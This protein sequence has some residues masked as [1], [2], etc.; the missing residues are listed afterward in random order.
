MNLFQNASGIFV[1]I[2]LEFEKKNLWFTGTNTHEG[3]RGLNV[4]FS[5][6]GGAK[7]IGITLEAL[8]FDIRDMSEEDRVFH[9]LK[10]LD[11]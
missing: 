7:K 8:M 5:G 6:I 3:K 4:P 10:G 9:F 11:E 1:S 2:P